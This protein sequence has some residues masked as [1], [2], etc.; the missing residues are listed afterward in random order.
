MLATLLTLPASLHA[1]G[2]TTGGIAGTV[3]NQQGLPVEGAQIQVT[4]V[5]TGL[6][7]TLTT[8]ANGRYQ[9]SGLEVATT[10]RVTA[11]RLGFRPL[12]KND[13]S[14]SLGETR[15]LNFVLEQ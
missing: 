3:T 5:S 7:A 13:V 14:I 12:V 11:K 15:R 2:S 4:N 8:G 1:Q 9:T 6:S 10:Y